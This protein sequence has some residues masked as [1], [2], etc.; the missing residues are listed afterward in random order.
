MKI[1][2]KLLKQGVCLRVCV[3]PCICYTKHQNLHS[4]RK[5]RPFLG[6]EAFFAGPQNSK[7]LFEGSDLVLRLGL[8][9]GLG[10]V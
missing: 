10:Q 2:L 6:S 3:C 5:G 1:T 7:G 8:E 4:T 9:L